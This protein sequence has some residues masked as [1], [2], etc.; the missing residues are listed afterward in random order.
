[1]IA[2]Q[3]VADAPTHPST[4]AT[5]P[6]APPK[7][8]K[9]LPRLLEL[10]RAEAEAFTPRD[11]SQ[12]LHRLATLCRDCD[13]RFSAARLGRGASGAVRAQFVAPA[14]ALL[15]DRLLAGGHARG[16]DAWGAS[17][18]V[19]SCGVLGEHDPELLDALCRATTAA[20]PAFK[21]ID[22][23]SA[24]VGWAWLRVRGPEQREAVDALLARTG[25]MLC[26][27]AAEWSAQEL[28]NVA[29]ALCKIGAA[30]DERRALMEALLNVAQ[31]RLAEF[32]PQVGLPFGGA[33]KQVR[34]R[35][36]QASRW[37]RSSSAAEAR[38]QW[39]PEGSERKV[40]VRDAHGAP[41]APSPALS[42]LNP[43]PSQPLPL[44]PHP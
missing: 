38:R 23:A 18:A 3:H 28:A 22:C 8:A 42:L 40:P 41:A 10:L 26:S 4:P 25:G 13:D 7:R 37:L 24:L 5:P 9:T 36:R 19:W 1:M 11:T 35:G 33:S 17:L 31:W 15:R 14:L 16:L 20:L 21:P 32:K 30:G 27:N 12:A 43:S 39:R 6:A 2:R 44:S 29:W 34:V